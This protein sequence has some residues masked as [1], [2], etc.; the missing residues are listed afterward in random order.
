MKGSWTQ[1]EINYLKKYGPS[2]PRAELARRLGR[3]SSSVGK[4]MRRKQLP[5]YEGAYRK[6]TKDEV[7][8]LYWLVERYGFR[9]IAKKMGRT[10]ASVFKKIQAMKMRTRANVHSMESAAKETG[11]HQ[12]QLKRARN[13]LGQRWKLTTYRTPG[14]AGRMQRYTITETQLEQL[15]EYLKNETYKQ[16]A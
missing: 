14:K 2:V 10:P 6:W 12:Y 7:A 1:E 11:Y 9:E 5:V 8:R 4:I 15:C 3:G 13:A 16:A